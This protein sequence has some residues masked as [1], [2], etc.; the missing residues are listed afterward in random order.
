MRAQAVQR[1]CGCSSSGGIQAGL[2]RVLDSLICW[3]A[4]L[5]MAGGSEQD[6]L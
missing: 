6:D 3:L 2:D 4:T 1:G 5:S